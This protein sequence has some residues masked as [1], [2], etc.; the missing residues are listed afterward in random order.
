ML[1]LRERKK[2]EVMAQRRQQGPP[3]VVAFLPLS[4]EV[5]FPTLWRLVLGAFAAAPAGKPAQLSKKK[6]GVDDMDADEAPAAGELSQSLGCFLS[7]EGR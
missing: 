6:G 2:S 7:L 3:L 4:T 1:V 5:D